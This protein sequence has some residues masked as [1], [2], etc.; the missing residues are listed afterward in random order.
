MKSFIVKLYIAQL[1]RDETYSNIY[2]K[3]TTLY[4]K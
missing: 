1:Y 4:K 2:F 3:N